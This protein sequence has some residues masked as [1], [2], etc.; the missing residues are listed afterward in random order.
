MNKRINIL[1][2]TIIGVALVSTIAMSYSYF[3]PNI[4]GNESAHT[5]T[6]TVDGNSAADITLSPLDGKVT[7][8]GSYPM[9]SSQALANVTPYTFTITNN[10]TTKSVSYDIILEVTSEVAASLISVNLGTTATTAKALSTCSTTSLQ[11][12]STF[13]T[14][15]K[16]GYGTTAASGSSTYN[17]RMWFNENGTSKYQ[18][19]NGNWVGADTDVQGK[20]VTSRIVVVAQ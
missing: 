15:Y 10:N 19:R 20:T 3:T 13:T 6:G 2:Y 4:S 11:S 9:T 8:S 14:A 1:V 5:V 7:L 17:F 18:D 16:I 12:G